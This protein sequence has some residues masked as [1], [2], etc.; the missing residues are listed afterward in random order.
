AWQFG[1][2]IGTAELHVSDRIAWQVERH[3]GRFGEVEGHDDGS[4]VFRT[5]YANLRQM[6]SFVLPLGE[7]LAVEGPEELVAEVAGRVDTLIERHEQPFDMARPSR[8]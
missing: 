8:A 7:H 2:T 5:D 1:D 6:A 4:I 3:F